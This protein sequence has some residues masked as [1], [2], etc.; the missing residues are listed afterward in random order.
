MMKFR[1]FGWFSVVVFAFA[2]FSLTASAQTSNAIIDWEML[3]PE[4][5]EFGILMP[6]NSSLEKTT[7]PYHKMTLNLRLYLWKSPSGPVFAVASIAG[8]KSNPAMYTEMERV[9]SYVDA[10]K[11]WFPKK[12]QSK[13]PIAKLTLVKE[14]ALNGHA[15]REYNMVVGDLS[16]VAEVYATKR[17]FY[18]IVALN[19]KKDESLIEKFLS[20]FEL[21]ERA[22][23]PPPTIARQ[24]GEKQ[25][26]AEEVLPETEPTANSQA[27]K[28][29]AAKTDGKPSGETG[30]T[31]SQPKSAEA[32]SGSEAPKRAPVSGGVLNGK[33][34]TLPKPEYPAAARQANVSGT[35]VVQVTIDEY[36]NVIS[37]RVVSG[38]PLLQA[39]A[40]AAA[41]EA[42][43]SPT[44]MMG[45]AVRVSGV[46]TY[47]F[48]AQ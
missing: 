21:P 4:G 25:A 34:I 38:H 18:A 1:I 36:G 20:S 31:E 45:E 17:R 30:A 40:V 16:G 13:D 24:K 23:E 47:Q 28:P 11:R 19:T 44:Y 48:V 22:N 5:E 41:R 9:N 2:A 3:R 46:L 42:K 27:Q 8:I 14:K 37:A 29:D 10:F 32:G 7:E 12:I 26:V 43:F 6:K 33:A 15:G 35:V 39:A